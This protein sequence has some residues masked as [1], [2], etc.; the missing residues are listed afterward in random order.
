MQTLYALI[1][2]AIAMLFSVSAQRSMHQTYEQIVLNEVATQVRGVG[3]EVLEDIGTS[4]FDAAADTTLPTYTRITNVTQLTDPADFGA[5][6]SAIETCIYI[7]GFDGKTTKR[8]VDGL[9]YTLQVEVRYVELTSPSTVSATPTY[10]KEVLLHI[11]SPHLRLGDNPLTVTMARTFTY[12]RAT[13][14]V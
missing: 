3:V 5:S 1:A 11:Q 10:A 2:L 4:F 8:T 9:K 14:T 13:V 7:E 6:C 12:Q